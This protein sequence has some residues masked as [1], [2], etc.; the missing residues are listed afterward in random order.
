MRSRI[1]QVQTD[2]RNVNQLQQ[3][4]Q[5]ALGPLLTNPA[6]NGRVLQGISLLAGPNIINHGLGRKL[7]GWMIVRQRAASSVYDAQDVN[8]QPALTLAL[9][10]SAPVVCDLYV[11]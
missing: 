6:L 2:D 9:V 8:T 5:A 11:F 10:V 7:V 1:T 3:N 4:V